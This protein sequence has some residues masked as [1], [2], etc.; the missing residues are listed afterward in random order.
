MTDNQAHDPDGI[1]REENQ[2]KEDNS[3]AGDRDKR[4]S[5]YTDLPFLPN[6]SWIMQISISLAL[7]FL[8]RMIIY[9]FIEWATSYYRSPVNQGPRM[10]LLMVIFI[11]FSIPW[12]LVLVPRLMD[13]RF[14]SGEKSLRL[15][16]NPS[17]ARIWGTQGSVESGIKR[18]YAN[19]VSFMTLVV[20]MIVA[21]SFMVYQHIGLSL[22][23]D[24]LSLLLR[25][26]EA[27]VLSLGLFF[28]GDFIQ[29]VLD[30]S[31]VAGQT[32]LVY[33]L[34][35]T[36]VLGAADLSVRLVV[37]GWVPSLLRCAI[38]SVFFARRTNHSKIGLAN[39]LYYFVLSNQFAEI[40]P[41]TIVILLLM[42][43]YLVANWTGWNRK[44]E[45]EDKNA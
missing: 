10:S 29:R 4:S 18:L 28:Y 45:V 43:I 9:L 31:P 2:G 37:L 22:P 7:L 27:G 32:G 17:L 19:P 23:V 34:V 5:V 40:L 41:L 1:D 30:K 38:L 8:G 25:I 12:L 21:A 24:I 26:Y 14:S 15:E 13:R 3:V 35:F 20:L 36:M 16:S 33:A 44:I 42:L 6:R 39:F 11:F